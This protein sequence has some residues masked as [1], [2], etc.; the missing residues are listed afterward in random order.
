MLTRNNFLPAL[1]AEESKPK[2]EN[3]GENR[4][5]AFC[6]NVKVNWIPAI[7]V[8]I[9]STLIFLSVQSGIFG[10]FF[11]NDVAWQESATEKKYRS[12]I[13]NGRRENGICVSRRDN[14]LE[15]LLRRL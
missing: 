3:V 10:Q 13:K 1:Q 5:K 14:N 8:A 2:T 12:A 7:V 15:C 11:F 4:R 9:L 6:R